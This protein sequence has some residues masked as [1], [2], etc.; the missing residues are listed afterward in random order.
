MIN[1]T[2]SKKQNNDGVIK[3]EYCLHILI[4]NFLLIFSWSGVN[5]ENIWAIF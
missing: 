1:V 3:M 2:Y 4:E 5:N